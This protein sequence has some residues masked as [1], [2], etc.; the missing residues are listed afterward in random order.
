MTKMSRQ[1]SELF[2]E[3][4]NLEG[5]L[6][7]PLS[8]SRY[9]V[10]ADIYLEEGR[11][12]WKHCF[13]ELKLW[14]RVSL[15]PKMLAEFVQLAEDSDEQILRYAQRY[16]VMN[17]CEQHGTPASHNYTC[18]S[19]PNLGSE[20]VEAWR[21]YARVAKAILNI[22]ARLWEGRLGHMEDWRMIRRRDS[23]GWLGFDKPWWKPDWK[24][25][26]EE[27]WMKNP[28]EFRQAIADEQTILAQL[29][30]MW[31]AIG[32]V[33]P[34]ISWIKERPTLTLE[35]NPRGKMF[36]ALACQLMLAV[37]RT[38]G[39]A[40]CSACGASYIPK[41]R[42]RQDQRRYCQDCGTA[43]AQRDAAADYRER[44]KHLRTKTGK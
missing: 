11:L 23:G 31:L 18:F 1:K 39:L 40:I 42:P 20:Q 7:R 36:G 37:S 38:D 41:R 22:A 26:P 3:L 29:V 27:Y 14:R 32:D 15:S 5:N 8:A 2:L 4:A 19:L 16:G 28:N 21:R 44:R 34:I 43:V 10:P 9:A 13:N 6:D 12:V 30:N 25:H 17:I 33:H 35:G 24:R